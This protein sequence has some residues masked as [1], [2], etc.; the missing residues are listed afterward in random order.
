MRRIIGQVGL[1][2][3]PYQTHPTYLTHLTSGSAAAIPAILMPIAYVLAGVAPVLEPV[4]AA[5]VVP[6]VPD[7]F[8]S[9]AAILG[10]IPYVFA[11]VTAVFSAVA[12]VLAPITPPLRSRP[13]LRP[14]RCGGHERD[15][16][17][18]KNHSSFHLVT[19]V[20]GRS[21][22]RPL[23]FRRSAVRYLLGR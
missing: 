15:H 16:Q 6:R 9:V 3:T 21:E 13:S 14:H 1:D 22:D 11:P 18:L 8:T 2:L 12:Y 23:H 20:P 19:P 10:T 4:A 7:V 5:A 17:S